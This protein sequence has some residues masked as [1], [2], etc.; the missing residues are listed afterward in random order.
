MKINAIE[1][2]FKKGQ[3]DKIMKAM[4]AIE[5]ENKSEFYKACDQVASDTGTSRE[6]VVF[7]ILCS[8]YQNALSIIAKGW[9]IK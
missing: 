3:L 6:D 2:K 9:G 8:T 5:Q 1:V 7:H 4:R